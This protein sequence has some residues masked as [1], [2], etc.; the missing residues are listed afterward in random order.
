MIAVWLY[1]WHAGLDTLLIILYIIS[2]YIMIIIIMIMILYFWHSGF[3]Y[4]VAYSDPYPLVRGTLGRGAKRAKTL[5]RGEQVFLSHH[6]HISFIGCFFNIALNII[7]IFTFLSYLDSLMYN[8]FVLCSRGATDAKTLMRDQHS[9]FNGIYFF[10][11]LFSLHM[12]SPK[13]QPHVL[14]R[15]IHIGACILLSNLP[16]SLHS[17]ICIFS[18]LFCL[19]WLKQLKNWEKGCNW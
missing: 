17:D 15:L 12:K 13:T 4:L 5:M 9:A 8:T 7:F 19:N 18:I 11:A 16:S 14:W 3:E 10:A 1:F 2:Y 6:F